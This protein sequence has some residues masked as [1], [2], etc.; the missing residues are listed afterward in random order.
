M[1]KVADKKE[2][3]RKYIAAQK[4]A[5]EK[6]KQLDRELDKEIE[7]CL[8]SE[9]RNLITEFNKGHLSE[10]LILNYFSI[11]LQDAEINSKIIVNVLEQFGDLGKNE[12][13]AIKIN[14]GW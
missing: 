10:E 7:N 3:K 9:L 13:L 8:S 1:S 11:F 6:A 12:A 14:E 5:E 4:E 2:E